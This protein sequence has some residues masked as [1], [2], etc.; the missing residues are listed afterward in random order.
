MEE[1]EIDQLD[2]VF[3]DSTLALEL[4]NLVCKNVK[5]YNYTEAFQ[6]PIFE[7]KSGVYKLEYFKK[8]QLVPVTKQPTFERFI[9][10]KVAPEIF[11][12]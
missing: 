2:Q 7:G 4:A 6:Q 12:V 9:I 11:S 5:K 1:K 10:Q 8:R 3:H